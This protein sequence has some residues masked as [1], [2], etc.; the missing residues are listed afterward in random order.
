MWR[1]WLI[2]GT[3]FGWRSAARERD[4]DLE[5]KDQEASEEEEQEE[6][7]GDPAVPPDPQNGGAV[8]L[9]YADIRALRVQLHEAQGLLQQVQPSV[10]QA[11]LRALRVSMEAGRNVLLS[12]QEESGPQ[13]CGFFLGCGRPQECDVTRCVRPAALLLCLFRTPGWVA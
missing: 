8:V 3:L 1:A 9:R 7:E 10:L 12:P 11:L 6:D 5:C 2:K 13:V 4:E